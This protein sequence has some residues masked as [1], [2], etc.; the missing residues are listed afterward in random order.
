[1]PTQVSMQLTDAQIRQIE[2]LTAAGFGNRSDVVR[3]AVDRMYQQETR[4][5]TAETPDIRI[6]KINCRPEI[7]PYRRYT[8]GMSVTALE[9]DPRDGTIVVDQEYPGNNSTTMDRYHRRTLSMT[10]PDHPLESEVRR[11]IDNSMSAFRDIMAGYDT[12]WDGHNHIGTYADDALSAWDALEQEA[13]T[14]FGPGYEWWQVEDWCDAEMHNVNA[15]TTDEELAS[16][17]VQWTPAEDHITII[18][19]ILTYI[20]GVRDERRD[21]DEE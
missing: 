3:I 1:M 16:L 8:G 10:L 20:T 18:G 19:D 17:A 13:N 4:T 7:D 14:G 15:G 12:R 6:V 11:W 2:A 21:N 5:M 9:F